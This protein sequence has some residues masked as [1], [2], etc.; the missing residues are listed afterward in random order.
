MRKE[1]TITLKD[2]ERELTFKVRE[3]SA[4]QLESW[5]IRAGLLLAGT[6]MLESAEVSKGAGDVMAQAGKAIAEGGLSALGKMDYEKAK[7]L[8][9]EL[10]ACCTRIDGGMEQHLTPEVVDGIIEDVKTLF[11][12]RKEALALNFGFFAS[13][14]PF[15]TDAG[16]SQRQREQSSRKISVHSQH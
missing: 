11:A 5:I 14:A 15:A 12:L 9:D 7:P 8:L 6:G 3:M 13:A 10:L 4:T 16:Q 1:K 2:R